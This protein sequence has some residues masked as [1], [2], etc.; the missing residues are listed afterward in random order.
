MGVKV[1]E[2]KPGEWWIFIC[3]NS[4]RRSKK[5]GDKKTAL[6]LAKKI[7]RRLALGDFDLQEKTQTPTFKE[8]AEQWLESFIKATRRH[9]TYERYRGILKGHVCPEIGTKRLDEIKRGDIRNLLLGLHKKGYSKSTIC[10]VRDVI[11]GP[12]GYA[13]DEELLPSNP[14]HGILR[15]LKLERSRGIEV[16]PMTPEEVALFLRICRDSYPEYYHFF[17]CALRTGM[18]LGEL[19]ALE[20]GDID[21]SS[22]FI[23]VQRSYKRERVEKTKT[24]KSRRIDMS[25]QL[26]SALK[27]LLTERKK[28]ALREGREAPRSVVFHRN[29]KHMEQN[30][31]RRIYK[32]VLAKA[33][34]REMRLHDTRHTF[35]SLLLSNGESPVYVKEQLGH[36]SI[37]MT[38]D[39][40]GHLIPSSN[41]HAVNKL[42]DLN[43]SAP[44]VHPLQ[45][46]KATT[47]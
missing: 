45:K 17:L 34:I 30:F 9:S 27:Q 22:K 40:Y 1:R 10:L 35:A 7:E 26:A 19:L 33:G 8:Y 4:N 37:Q 31:I 43:P 28:E 13:V 32:R 47:I 41:R 46:E 21:W 25:D 39:I 2:K 42:D 15:R 12:L 38:V 24:G 18:R 44:H 3:H 20:W 29:G 6:E 16:V 14:V 5:V 11:S 36:S 23:Q